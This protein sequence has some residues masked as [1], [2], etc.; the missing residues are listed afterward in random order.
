MVKRVLAALALLLSATLAAAQEMPPPAF[1]SWGVCPFECCTYRQWTADDD[2][3]VHRDRDNRSA[4]AFQLHRG[5][6]VDGVNGVVVAEQARPITIDSP[7]RDGYLAGSEKP[8]LT[9]NPGDV[10][11]VVAPLGE[12]AY[13][14][15]YQGRVYTSGAGLAGM[16]A[17]PSKTRFTW[18]KQV[19]NAAGKTGWTAS[20]KFSNVD[21]CG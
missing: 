19:K 13:R 14:F 11:V 3:P 5:D 9:L 15:W 16:L 6:A 10:V 2:I 4:L 20:E 12:G 21:A 8:Q 17:G 1:E 18:W 7:V